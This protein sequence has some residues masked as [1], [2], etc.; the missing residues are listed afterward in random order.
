VS[1]ETDGCTSCHFNPRNSRK[2]G[3][4]VSKRLNLSY[5]DDPNEKVAALVFKHEACRGLIHCCNQHNPNLGSRD[6]K[7][8]RGFLRVL[9]EHVESYRSVGYLG[10]V[11]AKAALTEDHIRFWEAVIQVAKPLLVERSTSDAQ[12]QSE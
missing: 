8:C 2:T 3:G 1:T 5:H 7:P 4:E 12:P 6:S 10:Y 11:Q 9:I